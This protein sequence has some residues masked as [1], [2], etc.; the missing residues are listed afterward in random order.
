MI[1]DSDGCIF[2]GQLDKSFSNEDLGR[3]LT[4]KLAGL[5]RQLEMKGH[6]S[7]FLEKFSKGGENERIGINEEE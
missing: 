5:A 3:L 4:V 1:F 2:K 6:I 7:Y